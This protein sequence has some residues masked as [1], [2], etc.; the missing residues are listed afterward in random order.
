MDAINKAFEILDVFLNTENDLSITELAKL[1]KISASTSHRITAILVDRGY[2]EQN[3][4]RGKYSLSIHKLLY[5]SG[6]LRKRLQVRNVALPF[7]KE[8][9]QT[10]NEAV[11]MSLRRGHSV[12]VVEVVN[13]DRLLNFAPDSS[14]F[15]LYSTGVGKIFLADMSAKDLEEYLSGIVLKP[16]TP[17]T[18]TDVVELKKQLNKIARE[19]VAFDD[20]EHEL[21]LRMVAAPVRDWD[22]NI[23][24]SIGVVGPANRISR[25][26][27]FELAPL[28]KQYASQISQ[29]LGFLPN[30]NEDQQSHHTPA[31]IKPK[32]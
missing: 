27:M 12:Y 30:A 31:T 7:L 32:Q 19:G 6:I 9:S 11:L 5:F 3:Q 18:I 13:S 15:A 14:T 1:A 21:G 2:L 23:I 28:V 22:Q 8:L 4:K 17:H 24:A 26:R 16:R 25:P 10:V 20:E 29:A